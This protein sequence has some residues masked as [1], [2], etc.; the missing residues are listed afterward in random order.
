MDSEP[1]DSKDPG[2]IACPE[3]GGDVC[4]LSDT[5]RNWTH[6]SR[7]IP[8]LVWI[9]LCLGLIGY[10]V[11]TGY[12]ENVWNHSQ[13]IRIQ[14]QSSTQVATS[15]NP[16]YR[17]DSDSIYVSTQ[18]LRDAIEG[19]PNAKSRVRE[20][21]TEASRFTQYPDSGSRIES[22]W[23]GWKDTLGSHTSNR[24]YRFGR[25][26]W[27]LNHSAKLQDVR[28][29]SSIGH[30]QYRWSLGEDGWTFFPQFGKQ[31]ITQDGA[32]RDSWGIDLVGVFRLLSMCLVIGVLI[33]YIGKRLRI[34]LLRKRY[35]GVTLMLI[36]LCSALAYSAFTPSEFK[37]VHGGH[38]QDIAQSE[39]YTIEYLDEVIKDDDKLIQLSRDLLALIPSSE[40][41]ELLLSQAWKYATSD[42][43]WA[44]ATTDSFGF[45]TLWNWSMFRYQKRSYLDVGADE[46]IPTRYRQSFRKALFEQGSLIFHWGPIESQR[47][48]SVDFFT[49]VSI[50]VLFWLIWMISH[51]S[52]RFILRRVQKRRVLRNQCIFCSYPLT[53]Q[54][55]NARYPRETT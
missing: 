39:A 8:R 9:V 5:R 15:L 28:H 25:T 41:R 46:Q 38:M 45:G 50:G 19:D 23:F 34:P 14:Q 24:S 53:A 35:S 16:S 42:T 36:M 40:N 10:W 22:I 31:T 51:W 49:I 3:C 44:T 30:D 48:L 18:D 52:A 29:L 43:K 54:A 7:M 21:I 26:L 4:E 17:T 37:R 1:A 2:H 27:I 13:P 20:N 47:T 11:S 6:R 33:G 12:L 55:V 32:V